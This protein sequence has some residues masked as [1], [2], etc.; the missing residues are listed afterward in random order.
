[1]NKPHGNSTHGMSKHKLYAVW[2]AMN[3]RCRNPKQRDFRLY[4]G[5]GITVC[6]RWK[7]FE[8][9]LSD[10]GPSW[11]CGLWLERKNNDGGYCPENCTW[12]TP[13]VQCLNKKN[14]KILHVSGKALNLSRWSRLA[15]GRQALVSDRLKRGWSPE[16]AVS[17]PIMDKCY[18][19]AHCL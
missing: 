2:N 14:G 9:F 13:S 10:M 18:F 4:G 15:G 5:R 12:E 7:R 8:N 11:K 17:R 1:M 6:D 19:S 3:Q 16:E